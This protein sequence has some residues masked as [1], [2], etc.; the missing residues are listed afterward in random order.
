MW[1]AHCGICDL[2]P[3]LLVSDT[4]AWERLTLTGIEPHY[5]KTFSYGN[6]FLITGI[7]V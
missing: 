1:L 3:L 7:C 4:T 6:C 5:M 2:G